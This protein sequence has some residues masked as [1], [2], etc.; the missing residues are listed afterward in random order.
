MDAS[1][2]FVGALAHKNRGVFPF[3][4]I[5][6]LYTTISGQAIPSAFGLFNSAETPSQE[7]FFHVVFHFKEHLVR[8]AE[9]KDVLFHVFAGRNIYEANDPPGAI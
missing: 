1:G 5:W 2:A 3:Q 6:P 4:Q 8:N 7:T 9:G